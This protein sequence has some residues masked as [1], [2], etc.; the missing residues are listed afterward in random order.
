MIHVPDSGVASSVGFCLP[1]GSNFLSMAACDPPLDCFST[2]VFSWN[3]LLRE[4]GVSFGGME[5]V[6]FED[7]NVIPDPVL[8]SRIDQFLSFTSKTMRYFAAS[9]AL[10]VGLCVLSVYAQG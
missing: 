8:F 10:L 4:T 2:S 1:N 6:K 3:G 7:D 5:V 9:I